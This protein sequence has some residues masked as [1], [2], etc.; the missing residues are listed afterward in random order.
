MNVK[1]NKRVVESMLDQ[2]GMSARDLAKIA[3]LG[4]ATVYR[5]MNGS[6]FNS[7]T[8]GKLALALECSPIDLIDT[9]GYDSPQVEAPASA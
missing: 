3:E 8:L 4:E 5:I 6:T 7:E 1:I 2:R 9:Q